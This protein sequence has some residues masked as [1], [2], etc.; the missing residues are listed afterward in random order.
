MPGVSAS[1]AVSW[2]VLP[3]PE[4]DFSPCHD[5]GVCHQPI[6]V[7]LQLLANATAGTSPEGLRPPAEPDEHTRYCWIVG[8]QAA[9][10]VWRLLAQRLHAIA[11]DPAPSPPAVHATARL[12]DAYTLLFFYTGHCS[13]ERYGAT[14]RA[15][16]MA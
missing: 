16:M 14:V 6:G 13:A 9:F 12:Y 1:G 11:S 4:E 2:L 10:C 15:D 5:L 7:D 8:H 3:L